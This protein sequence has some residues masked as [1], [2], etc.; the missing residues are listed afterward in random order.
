M[1]L[2]I[3]NTL[4]RDKQVFTPIEPN[5][6]RLYVCGM[7]VYDYCHLGHA[8]VLVAFDVI[9]RYLRASGYTVDYVR[10]ITDIDDKIIDRAQRNGEPFQA[11]TERFIAAMH[12]D[13]ACLGVLPPDQE[14]R[15][16]AHMGDI[17]AMVQTLVD[18]GYAYIAANG[19]VYYAVKKFPRYGSLSGKKPDE[20]LAG[21]RIE[22]GDIKRDHRDF[23]LWK[24][25]SQDEAHWNSPWGPGR[26]GWHIECSAMSRS[27]LGA[28]FDIHGGGPDLPFPHHENEIAQSEAANGCQFVN[29]WMHAGAVRVDGEKMSK[30]LGNFFTIREILAEYHPEVVRYLLISSQYRSAI[31]YSLETLQTARGALQRLYTALRGIALEEAPGLQALDE[32]DAFVQRFVAAMD[33]D[34][35]TPV[36]LSVLFEL[37]RELNLLRADGKDAESRK[38]ARTLKG[39][40]SVLGLLQEDPESFL[41][42]GA[43]D[44]P[45]DEAIEALVAE[46]E[47]AKR[48]KN[49]ARAD[50]IREQLKQQGVLLEDGRGGTQWKR[51]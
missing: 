35:N 12:E 40:G 5:K 24:A 2:K 9:T 15:A 8:R 28:H 46:R 10:N 16:T 32:K 22:T 27:C 21:A 1:V 11:L 19:D 6:I 50:E 42:S 31:N 3:Y 45:G 29:Y 39:L 23:A 41:K 13:E 30:S 14:P 37:V 36:A 51:S 4:A 20:L 18:K 49:Y 17:I 48:E 47:Q 33:D 26:P 38:L 25:T 7:T 34:F 43:A 44:A